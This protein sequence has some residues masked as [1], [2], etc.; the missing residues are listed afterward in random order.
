MTGIQDDS[1]T[2]NLDIINLLEDKGYTFN[3]SRL[4]DGLQSVV[5]TLMDVE[6]SRILDANRYERSR[7]RRAYRNGYRNTIW[8][9][10][11]GEVEL[12]IPKL[13]RG[14]YY[15]DQLLNDQRLM[16]S[17]IRLIKI[18]IIYGVDH[19]A[20]IDCLSDLDF[21]ALTTYEQHQICEALRVLLEDE[22]HVSDSIKVDAFMLS[23]SEYGKY[24]LLTTQRNAQDQLEIVRA[25][26]TYRLD[27]SFWRDFARRMAQSGVLVED[28]QSVLS[29]INPY[30]LIEADDNQS[31]LKPD[32]ARLFQPIYKHQLIA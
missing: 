4:Q 3:H 13:R 17:L 6:I 10:P 5:Q 7:T 9:T 16:N 14:S 20:M 12:R 31:I 1:V 23:P 22:N 18:A 30:A 2:H 19:I 11:I 32:F 21:I 27:Q 26:E 28:P 15:P 24:L 29:S 8:N 25:E